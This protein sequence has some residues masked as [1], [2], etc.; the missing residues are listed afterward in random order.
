VMRRVCVLQ[1]FTAHILL[2]LRWLDPR[3]Q[4]RSIAPGVSLLMREGAPR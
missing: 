4:Y 3:L 2:R 1:Q